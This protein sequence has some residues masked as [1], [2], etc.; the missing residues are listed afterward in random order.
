MRSFGWNMPVAIH[1]GSGVSQRIAAELKGRACVVLA[2]DQA[3]ELGLQSS[4]T[5]QLGT[6]M[7]GWLP[8]PCGPAMLAGAQQLAH[9]LW[10]LLRAHP[11]AVV[12]ALGGGTVM[13]LAKV[14]R[15]LPRDSGFEALVPALRGQTGWPELS[16][17]DLWLAP[18]TAG[19][20][21]ELNRWATL[22]E[23][24]DGHCIQQTLDEPFGWASKAFIDPWLTAT[25]PL[26]L[27]RNAALQTL[28]LALGSIWSIHA[29]PMG[30]G[31]GVMAARQVI[32]TLPAVLNDPYDLEL[33]SELSMAA[34]HA[35]L[36]CSQMGYGQI[37]E[38][39]VAVRPSAQFGHRTA[40]SSDSVGH[41]R[42][43]AS[44]RLLPQ[45]WLEALGVNAHTDCLLGSIFGGSPRGGAASL[46][47]WLDAVGVPAHLPHQRPL[48]IRSA[49]YAMRNEPSSLSSLL[50]T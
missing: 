27:T 21:K 7:L 29:H 5:R 16:C 37:H 44:A 25:C 20:G 42:A 48:Q 24:V 47:A 50:V 6:A 8:V 4:W 35:G 9:Q 22:H 30:V 12:V 15:C 31:Q 36:A 19:T 49:P 38:Q 2:F 33:R 43:G 1:F 3:F 23:V 26:D 45:T 14:L 11:Q 18:S 34:L 28:G 17:R 39:T 41:G 10:P 13:D 46:A 32:A 40:A